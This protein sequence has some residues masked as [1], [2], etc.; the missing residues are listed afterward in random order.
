MKIKDFIK[1]LSKYNEDAEIGICYTTYGVPG[2]GEL[3]TFCEPS[4]TEDT[5][6]YGKKFISIY[7]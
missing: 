1:E 6:S 4:I 2:I 3:E 5:D 7:P